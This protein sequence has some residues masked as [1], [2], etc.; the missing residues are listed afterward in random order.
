MPCRIKRFTAASKSSPKRRRKPSLRAPRGLLDKL[1]RGR[2][3]EKAVQRPAAAERATSV[4]VVTSSSLLLCKRKNRK[5]DLFLDA[6]NYLGIGQFA[7][8]ELD[9]RKRG[10]PLVQ[11]M[12]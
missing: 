7:D 8:R 1:L 4:P 2:R 10:V 3:K 11:H 12:T 5:F 9:C 6:P